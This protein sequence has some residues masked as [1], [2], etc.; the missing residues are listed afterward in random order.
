MTAGDTQPTEP[1]PDWAR[2]EESAEPPRRR[3]RWGWIVAL[4]VVV[5]LVV[6]AWFA[7]EAIAR[8][9]V[10]GIV[11]DQV[12]SQLSLPA[13]Q[14]IDVDIPGVLIPQLIGG[15]LDQITVSSP[16]VVI[17]QFEGDV[18]VT[19]REVPI[20]NATAMS[21]ADAVVRLDAEQLRALMSTV[22][23]FPADSLGL[24]APNVTMATDL[25]L[26]GISFPVGA[27]LTP[28]AVEGDIVLTPA[29]V[30]LGENDV[31]AD[32]LREQ[33]G[34]LA[35]TVLRDWT[36]CIAQYLPSGATLSGVAVEGEELVASFDVA[37][38]ILS[39]P[40]LQANGTCG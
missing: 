14:P 1:L 29:S 30:R 35:G 12:R 22:E 39:D 4:I 33:F 31:T 36:V 20:R 27:A 5:G 17:Q 25:Q 13:E 32:A 24:A 28:S 3:R 38:G 11:Q 6:G 34:D 40:A 7:A 15:T 9:V 18:S 2:L 8:Q 16:D 21:G 10:T 26:F 37:G 23:G 19:A